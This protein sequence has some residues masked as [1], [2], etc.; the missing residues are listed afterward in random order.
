[1]ESLKVQYLL[2]ITDMEK[3]VKYSQV[4]LLITQFSTTQISTKK[5]LN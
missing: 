1:M 2:F 3:V 4:T 5:L